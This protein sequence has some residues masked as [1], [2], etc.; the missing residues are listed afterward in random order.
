MVAIQDFPRPCTVRKLQSF[1]GMVNFSRRFLPGVACTLQPLTD[2]LSG[3]RKVSE[4][5]VPI[6][7]TFHKYHSFWNIP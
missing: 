1:L 6:T 7:V 5:K 2:K 4:Q 3:S